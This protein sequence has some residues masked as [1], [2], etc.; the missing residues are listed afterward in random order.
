MSEVKESKKTVSKSA[1][2]APV[3]KVAQKNIIE[4][5]SENSKFCQFCGEN[6]LAEAD[7]CPKCGKFVNE[8]AKKNS[9][10]ANTNNT[11]V[12]KILS[13]CGILWLIGLLV[14]EKN[15]KSVKFHVGQGMLVTIVGVIL[16]VVAAI[17]NS[18]IIANIF[19]TEV[20]YGYF[21]T[22]VYA[23]S[24]FGL[25]LISLINFAVWAVVIALEIIGIINAV[26]EKDKEL[27]IIGKYAF[28]K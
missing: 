27:P 2:K 17:I 12:Y 20:T 18:V 8:E 19:K 21:K 10:Q 16:N 14:P 25:V 4:T 3:K 6:I 22:G 1:T 23:T 26:K 7:V 15:D 11:K 9:K 28:Y 24:S 5:K 13:Y